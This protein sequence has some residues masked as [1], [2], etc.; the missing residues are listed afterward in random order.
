MRC[1]LVAALSLVAAASCGSNIEYLQESR[2]ATGVK[3]GEV[4]STSAIVW[5]RVTAAASRRA[6]GTPIRARVVKP[7]YEE[8]PAGHENKLVV[9]HE[10]RDSQH[11]GLQSND[12]GV[13]LLHKQLDPSGLQHSVPGAPGRVR[14]RYADNVN[15]FNPVESE[16][17]EVSAEDD[18]THHFKLDGLKPATI[19]YVETETSDAAGAVLH[20]PLNARF[21]TAPPE[22]EYAAVTFTVVTGQ[23]NHDHDHP[24]GFK[25]YPSMLELAPNFIVPTGDTVYYDSDAPLA[26][27]IDLAR[28]H[29]HRMYSFPTILE[30]HLSV[31][32]YWEKDDH[33]SYHNDNWPGMSRWYM[34]TFS[35]EQGLKVY[36]E[37]APMSEL[38][39]RT[40]RWGKG[41]QVWVVE[42]RDFRSPNTMEDGPGK[43]I[44][45]ETQKSWLKQTLLESNA[46]WK[47]LVSPTPIVGPDRSNKNDNHANKGFTREGDEMR[48]WFAENLPDNFFIACGDRHWQ[49]HSVHPATGVQEFSSGPATDEHAGGSPGEDGDYHRFHRV[50]GG[51][52][53]ITAEK[54]S[55]K[56]KIAF[57]FHDVDGNVVYEHGREKT[58]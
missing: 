54:V 57:R 11:S 6:D 7:K 24:D 41:L 43:S 4:T 3:I 28:F 38:P 26:T 47:V 52:L 31:P 29:W 22:N 34:G 8:P 35:W 12:G 20:K 40:F 37:Q 45:G 14:L 16:W 30:F 39:Y 19:Y 49:Y 48:Q 46:D 27:S 17:F 5:T 9:Q 56:S 32:G 42:G 2:Q 21:E 25:I 58:L 15:F 55:D 18:Y 13:R 36:S 33:D 1:F 53:S 23:S 44:W 51:F 50:A 10:P